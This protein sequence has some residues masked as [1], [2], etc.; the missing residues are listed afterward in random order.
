MILHVRFCQIFDIIKTIHTLY[1]ESSNF[2]YFLR[3]E[4][5]LYLVLQLVL[6]KC[7]HYDCIQTYRFRDNPHLDGLA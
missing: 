1:I 5:Y 2:L 3:D 4:A 7:R 6:D